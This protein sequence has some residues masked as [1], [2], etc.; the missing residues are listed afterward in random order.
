[1]TGIPDE[2]DEI[3]R[4]NISQRTIMSPD[5]KFREI[6]QFMTQLKESGELKDLA[7][8]GIKLSENLNTFS[9]RQISNP[10]LKL[11]KDRQVE[12]NKEANFK[13]VD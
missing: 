9:A 3:R 6:K 11:G 1:M 10:S 8:M 4:R 2:F 12:R 5:A 13:L 7:D